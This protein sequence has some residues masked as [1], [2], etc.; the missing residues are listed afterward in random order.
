MG[1]RDDDDWIKL[2]TSL[3]DHPKVVGMAA[4]V[5]VD[6]LHVVGALA[7]TWS[8]FKKHAV[9]NRLVGYTPQALNTKVKMPGFAEA[10][11]AFDWL[12]VE[13]AESPGT[14]PALSL[15]RAENHNTAE[16][17]RRAVDKAR[18]RAGREAGAERAAVNATPVASPA[19][20]GESAA[21]AEGGAGANKSGVIQLAEATTAANRLRAIGMNVHAGMPAIT[22]MVSAGV[23]PDQMA[24]TAAEMAIRAAGAENN[25]NWPAIPIDLFARGAS[26]AQMRITDK[27]YC[28]LRAALPKV[29]HLSATIL[30]R[31]Q[32]AAAAAAADAIAATASGEAVETGTGIMLSRGTRRQGTQPSRGIQAMNALDELRDRVSAGKR[33]ED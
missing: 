13:P 27:F 2:R 11:A 6:P 10:M 8:T 31:M 21:A 30:G 19:A 14:L 5:G 32:D 1:K 9:D 25:P 7:A 24:L 16:A 20:A 33:R 12:T 28:M 26:A 18:K 17:R 23:T 22:R 3:E 4:L 29:N 15:P